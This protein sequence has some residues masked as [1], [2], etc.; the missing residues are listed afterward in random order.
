VPRPLEP[1]RHLGTTVR[2]FAGRPRSLSEAV[3]RAAATWPERAA[4][5][6]PTV[7]LTHAEHDAVVDAVAGGLAG[8]G[9]GPGGTVAAV[10]DHDALLA[11]LPFACSRIGARALLLSAALPPGRWSA[12]LDRVPVDLVL[13]GRTHE[14]AARVAA[15]DRRLVV[16]DAPEDLGGSWS[17]ADDAAADEDAPVA[18]LATSGTTGVAKVAAVTSRGLVHT[19]LAYAELLDLGP[20]DR[21]LVVLPLHYIGPLSA[22]TTAMACVGGC[23]VLPART[24]AAG[25]VATMDAEA[26]THLDAVPAWLG[27][28]LRD[29]DPRLLPAWRTLIYGGA[30]MPPGTA[31]GLAARFPGLALFD[32]WGLSETHGAATARRWSAEPVPSGAVGRPVAGVEVRAVDAAGAAVPAGATGELVVRGASVFPGYVD[33]AATT[34]AVLRDGWLATG[35]VGTVD[36]DGAVRVLDRR[37]DVIL[38]GGAN[39]FSVEVEAVLASAPGIAEAAVYGVA[40]RLGGEA[41][42][43]AVV[44]RPGAV[45]DVAAL[46]RRVAGR[47]G[48]HAA[49]RRITAL[50]VLPRNA[51]GKIDKQRLR[52]D[53]AAPRIRP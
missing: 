50:D 13:A 40:D 47:I 20:D 21:S 9:I 7:A 30:P 52:A 31:A 39:V 53:D 28:L 27:Q 24:G 25:T 46:R 49:P 11:V 42:A 10:L 44:L 38:R 14:A 2:A 19:A 45:L 41:V 3:R 33:D 17:S 36:V 51:T 48:V 37:K 26:I 8:R 29:P 32:V 1:A 23:A 6:T 16:A 5:Q 4:L 34:A 43:A 35:D 12:Q 18:L 15:G 22:Q